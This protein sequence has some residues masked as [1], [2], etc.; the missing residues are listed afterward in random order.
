MTSLFRSSLLALLVLSAF[1]CQRR[2]ALNAPRANETPTEDEA[3]AQTP[4][5]RAAANRRPPAGA[6]CAGRD[7]CPTSQRCVQGRCAYR[8]S[9]V[10]GEIL[11]RAAEAQVAHGDR[12]GALMTYEKALEAYTARA[13]PIPPELA[14]GAA[15]LSLSSAAEA[16]ARERGARLA[17]LCFRVSV[18]GSRLRASVATALSRLRFYG[19]DPALFEESEP[20]E[21]F[22]TEEAGPPTLDAVDIRV[23]TKASDGARAAVA[24]RLGEVDAVRA[25]A[26]CFIDD[27]GGRHERT[28]S[29]HLT[30][31]YRTRARGPDGNYLQPDAEVVPTGVGDPD[32][33]RCVAQNFASLLTDLPPSDRGETWTQ[34]LV[35]D[36]RLP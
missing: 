10:S 28:A 19:L 32:F 1:G 22:F 33:E 23:R 27:F 21:R 3:S 18:P 34:A 14:C 16:E 24:T 5:P 36:A 6:S 30:V 13:A 17:D 20:A 25:A 15:Q 4:E 2:A 7:D 29:A 35:V 26:D 12:A 8:T 31:R 9:S 11:T